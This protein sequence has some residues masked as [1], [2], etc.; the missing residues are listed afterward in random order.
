VHALQ[1]HFHRAHRVTDEDIAE[2]LQYEHDPLGYVL[3]PFP[4]GR[5]AWRAGE[6][7]RARAAGSARLWLRPSARTWPTPRRGTKPLPERGR[8]SGH[9][10]GKSALI[11]MVC[12]WG[13]EHLPERARGG[14]GQHR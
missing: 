14:H 5:S 11:G 8:A 1:D 7:S 2:V 4:W 12:Q 10:I 6:A 13:H 9:G 3:S